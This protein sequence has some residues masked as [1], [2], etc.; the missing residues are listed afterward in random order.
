[1]SEKG[2]NYK[3]Q[4]FHFGRRSL[5]PRLWAPPCANFFESNSQL[6]DPKGNGGV[7]VLNRG[8]Y[9]DRKKRRALDRIYPGVF[10][11]SKI[12]KLERND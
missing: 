6:K 7:E 4:F 8:K 9:S 5:A 3:N 2:A 11:W 1:M 12:P 10:F